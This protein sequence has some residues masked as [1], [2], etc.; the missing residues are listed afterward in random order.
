MFYNYF[1]A[2]TLDVQ[3]K[4]TTLKEEAEDLTRKLKIFGKK[5]QDAKREVIQFIFLTKFNEKKFQLAD[6]ENENLQ[7]RTE[8]IEANSQAFRE[9]QKQEFIIGSYIPE[10]YLVCS[11]LKIISLSRH[12]LRIYLRFD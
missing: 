2:E 9:L 7:Q 4:Y 3:V 8:L 1:Q 6:L 10:E 5:Y 11:F 12:I